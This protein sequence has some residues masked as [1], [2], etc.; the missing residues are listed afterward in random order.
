MLY[1]HTRQTNHIKCSDI[2]PS[3]QL[4]RDESESLYRTHDVYLTLK[5]YHVL[6]CCVTVQC[7]EINTSIPIFDIGEFRDVHAVNNARIILLPFE[8][9]PAR[10]L[11]FKGPDPG[12]FTADA[13]GGRVS[14]TET[15]YYHTTLNPIHSIFFV[16]SETQSLEVC[17]VG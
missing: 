11:F 6:K 14:L 9:K 7:I 2:R 3:L 10:R 8:A 1:L 13:T 15:T 17:I 5:S 12:A 4:R 16:K